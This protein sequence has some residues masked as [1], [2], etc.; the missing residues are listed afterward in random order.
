[1]F[2]RLKLVFGCKYL[3]SIF[4]SPPPLLSSQ[5]PVH[6]NCF[7]AT[8]FNYKYRESG[9]WFQVYNVHTM[10]D[11]FMVVSGMPN[12]IGNF[13]SIVTSCKFFFETELFLCRTLIL[14]QEFNLRQCRYLRQDSGLRQGRYFRQDSGL[15]LQFVKLSI[16]QYS[17][18]ILVSGM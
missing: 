13:A 4:I 7:T 17:T 15:R 9:S 6:L 18:H 3:S 14:R 12:K 10:A 16:H 2:K 8:V 5:N 1:M 11:E